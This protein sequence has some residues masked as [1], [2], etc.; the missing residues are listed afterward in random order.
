M[1]VFAFDRDWTV[2]VN[3]HPR[4]EAVPLE[5]VQYLAHETGHHVYAIGNQTLA[6]EAAIPGV[7]DIVGQHPDEWSDWLG[8]KEP[9]GYYEDFP[10]RRERLSLIADLHPDADEYIVVDDIDLSD[11]DDWSHY[12]AWEFV[13][14]IERGA[15]DPSLPWTRDPV[16]DGGLPTSAG[17]VPSDASHLSSFLNE[18]DDS[19]VF[20]LTYSEAGDDVTA[21]LWHLSVESTHTDESS[22]N[23]SVLCT[24][25]DP[26]T[27]R[28]PAP[29][30]AIEKLSV[31]DPP[32]EAFTAHADTPTAEAT[33]RRRAAE[34][35]PDA[36]SVS[37]ILSLLDREESSTLVERDALRALRAVAAVRATECTP[38]VPILRSLLR[39]SDI[40]SPHDALAILN[41]IGEYDPADI[42][43][44]IGEIIPYLDSERV[45]ARCEA[46]GCI[47][48][49]ASEYPSDAVDA[50]PGLATVL[51]DDS[52][53]HDAAVAALGHIAREHPEAVTPV[54]SQL[55]DVVRDDAASDASRMHG[56]AALG[57]VIDAFPGLAVEII[58]DVARLY[59]AENHKLRN[60]AVAL[61]F[62]AAAIH[63][64]VV[65][66]YVDDI[67]ALLTDD[68]DLIR[69]NASGTLARV[70][71]DF[72]ES[73]AHL[74]PT[75]VDLLGDDDSRVRENACWALGYLRTMDA[76]APL[77]QRVAEDTAHD[78]Q[79][80]AAW[81][82]S[83]IRDTGDSQ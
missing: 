52:E 73:V 37:P 19:S 29:V 14:A 41:S 13:P 39:Q 74:T 57:R 47:A 48:A 4:R 12:H 68:D 9:D 10:T 22:D 45:P 50:V 65:E 56:T 7:V 67:A 72:P 18:Q 71:E 78:V 6:E 20:Q 40:A 70:A 62:E 1:R 21:L 25:L 36:V 80:R 33:A 2:D 31:V 66:P 83:Q 60:N 61:T 46:A 15:I 24:P 55:R 30:D 43:P 32:V 58:D 42:A 79:T 17:I 53:G 81:A 64:D 27:D 49:I 69:T 51:D 3:P 77:K 75:L 28:F 38:A 8:E 26:G 59:E 35:K 63:T 11:V 76:L 44:T 54:A 34:A 23:S 5:W 16:T 82:V